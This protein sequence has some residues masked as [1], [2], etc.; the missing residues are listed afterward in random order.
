MS[1]LANAVMHLTLYSET[2][3]MN[4][5]AMLA[6][7]MAQTMNFRQADQVRLTTPQHE[8]N[9]LDS[10]HSVKLQVNETQVDFML[11]LRLVRL[12]L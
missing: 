8:S 9:L 6:S 1:I 4:T 7:S 2:S 5:A 11:Q 12:K 10:Q 3:A